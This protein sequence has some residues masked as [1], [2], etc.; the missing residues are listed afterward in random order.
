MRRR[1]LLVLAM[2][3]AAAAAPALAQRKSGVPPTTFPPADGYD[4]DAVLRRSREL[5]AGRERSGPPDDSRYDAWSRERELRR[6]RTLESTRQREIETRER[7]QSEQRRQTLRAMQPPSQQR[8]PGD[9]ILDAE[10]FNRLRDDAERAR[11]DA[12]DAIPLLWR[13]R[14]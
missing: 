10:K 3:A 14:P 11:R 13:Q 7:L 1:A 6:D 5:D 2:L 8:S 12:D 4:I 9:Q